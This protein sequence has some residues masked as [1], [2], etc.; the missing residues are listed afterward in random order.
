[1]LDP[2]ARIFPFNHISEYSGEQST[3]KG[4]TLRVYL[5][6]MAMQGI[7]SSG[8]YNCDTMGIAAKESVEAADALINELNK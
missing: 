7:L 1:M 3:N 5:S 8:N 6:A 2:N 4:M